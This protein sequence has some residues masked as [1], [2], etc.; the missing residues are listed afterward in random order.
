MAQRVRGGTALAVVGSHQVIVDDV[1]DGLLV[2]FEVLGDVVAELL[3]E[4]L[5]LGLGVVIVSL[6]AGELFEVFQ[7]LLAGAVIG[8]A[9]VEHTLLE[10]GIVFV[11]E[12]KVGRL[13]HRWVLGDIVYFVVEQ[14]LVG[15]ARS[16]QI[17]GDVGQRVALD[18]HVGR[19]ATGIEHLAA[20]EGIELALGRVGYHLRRAAVIV[21]ILACLYA[22]AAGYVVTAG[23]HLHLAVV[24]QVDGHLHQTL[25]V[26]LGTEH[27]GAVHVLQGTGDNLCR[28]GRVA[29]DHHHNGY[30]GVYGLAGG[31]VVVVGTLQL[32]T[33]GHYGHA[34]GHKEVYQI[35]CLEFRTAAIVAQV[36]DKSL[37]LLV[38]HIDECVAHNLGAVLCKF[39]ELD[40]PYSTLLHAV[41]GHCGHLDGPT[42]NLEPHLL[43]CRGSAYLEFEGGTGVA[44]QMVAHV[45]VVLALHCLAV[46]AE[47]HVALAQT[48]FGGRHALIGLLD[49]RVADLRVPPYYTAYARILA[50]EHG[51]Q[52][53]GLVFRVVHRVGVQTAQHAVVGI[54]HHLLVVEGIDIKQV[55]MLVYGVEN[56]Q[57]FGHFKIVVFVLGVDRD[58][59]RQKYYYKY[60]S[61]NMQK[62]E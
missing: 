26:G 29:V 28:R 46:D 1:L 59:H 42:R 34:L 50:R 39:I 19:D 44:T 49:D 32:A 35:G 20:V 23:G 37:N 15:V 41:I 58:A 54:A 21:T 14:H 60:L 22:A 4:R 5:E 31:L 62:Y 18:H 61:H 8:E 40:I 17:V 6:K 43:A 13:S 36:K 53:V 9:R 10:L 52:L 38:A 11:G 2:V 45:G 24:R 47:Y 30:H 12:F 56:F 33:V 55:E 16:R 48:G 57:V 7:E 3:L 27:H 25:A 51:A